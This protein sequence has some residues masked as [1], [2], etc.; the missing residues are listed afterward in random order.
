M[1]TEQALLALTSGYSER[2]ID[3]SKYDEMWKEAQRQYERM[4][5]AISE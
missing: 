2:S 3:V 4:N 1:A 5:V